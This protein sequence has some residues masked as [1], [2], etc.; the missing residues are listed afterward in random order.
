[1]WICLNNAFLSI[2]NSDQDDS[3]LMVRA[4]RHGDIEATFGTTY[5]VTTLPGRDYQFRAFIPR[6]V[7][8][9]VIAAKLL[10]IDYTNFKNSVADH[11]LH[12]AYANVWHTMAELQEV[13]PYRTRPRPGFNKYPKR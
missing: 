6:G 7:V 9:N 2:V 10:D 11:H 3:V 8:G 5:P 1:M 13:A 12:N 4:R